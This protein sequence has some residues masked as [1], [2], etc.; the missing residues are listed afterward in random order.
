[1]KTF[2]VGVDGSPESKT[3]AEFAAELARQYEGKLLLVYCVAIA[4]IPEPLALE[5][6][7]V[8]ERRYGDEVI[9]EAAA[10][11]ARPGVSIERQLADGSPA[12]RLAEIAAERGVDFVVIGHRG[13][14]AVSRF[15]LGSVAD[16]LVQTSPKPVL[17][18]R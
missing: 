8:A 12:F 14:G 13:R 11:C 2:L 7:V 6:F 15:L 16:R 10:R 3:A 9:R 18:V 5:A 4:A 1:M 17:V